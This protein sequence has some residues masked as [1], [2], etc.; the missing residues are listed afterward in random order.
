MAHRTALHAGRPIRTDSPEHFV[1]DLVEV[2]I[3]PLPPGHAPRLARQPLAVQRLKKLIRPA[4]RQVQRIV[5]NN[6]RAWRVSC[7]SLGS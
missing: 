6:A 3:L 7:P 4:S 2:G 5:A 1:A